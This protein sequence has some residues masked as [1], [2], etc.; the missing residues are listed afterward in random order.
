MSQTAYEQ[1]AHEDAVFAGDPHEPTQAE[2]DNVNMTVLGIFV[3]GL[4]L[5]L[6]VLVIGIQTFFTQTTQAQLVDKVYSRVDPALNLLRTQEAEKLN[7]YRWV[8]R[9]QGIVRIPVDRASELVL[10]EWGSRKAAA[11]ALS[12]SGETT[13]AE[14][15]TANVD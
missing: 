11:A 10:A 1:A 5:I 7:E 4:L 9:S 8:N 13:G 3:A 6:V 15:G 2:P 14:S 12:D